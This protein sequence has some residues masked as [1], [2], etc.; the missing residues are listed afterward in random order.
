MR[1]SALPSSIITSTLPLDLDGRYINKPNL[2][3]AH[4]G[5]F[6]V[7]L[8]YIRTSICYANQN[9]NNGKVLGKRDKY[10]PKNIAKKGKSN[11]NIR[12]NEIRVA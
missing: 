7:A 12:D 2:K 9:C 8:N 3:A 6:F 10:I 4:L 11:E 5:G 1:K